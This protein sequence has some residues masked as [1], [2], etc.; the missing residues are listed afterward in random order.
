MGE[1]PIQTA[2]TREGVVELGIDEVLD[3]FAEGLSADGRNGGRSS[4]GH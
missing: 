4:V 3:R 1:K 2:W